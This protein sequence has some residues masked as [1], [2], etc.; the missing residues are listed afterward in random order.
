M[1]DDVRMSD[2]SYVSIPLKNLIG[3]IV[4]ICSGLYAYFTINQR[5]QTLENSTINLE[6]D[7]D[8]NSIWIDEWESG[9]ML[10]LDKEQNLFIERLKED[11]KDL[12]LEMKEMKKELNKKE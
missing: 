2:A 12:R 10:P 11:V 8:A 5:L 7:I 1:S 9:G 3:L 6:K 4:A